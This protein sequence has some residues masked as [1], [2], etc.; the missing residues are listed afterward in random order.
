[1]PV[2]QLTRV[3]IGEDVQIGEGVQF[4]SFVVVHD[5]V[6]IGDGCVVQDGAVLGKPP[7]LGARSRAPAPA[8]APVVIEA[9]VSVCCHAVIC[10]GAS[11]G[12]GAVV[13]D[14]AFVREG[15]RIGAETVVGQGNVI[16]RGVEL[17]ARVRLQ[18]KVV[19]APGSRLEDDVFFGPGVMITNDPSIG[20]SAQTNVPVLGALAR[21][22]CRVGA[23]VVLLPGIEIGEEAMVGAG[24]VVTRSVPA[25]TVVMGAPAKAVRRVDPHEEL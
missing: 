20:R 19:T 10:A 22:A 16:S 18:A 3:V 21:R 1:M 8:P 14:H 5:G 9:G 25:R 11:I 24:S 15:A 6:R 12:A 13:G 17:G 7:R 23:S 4:G 2:S